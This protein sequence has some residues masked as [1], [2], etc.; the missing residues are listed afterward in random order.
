MSQYVLLIPPG[1]GELPVFGIGP[2]DTK[3]EA[4]RVAREDWD[5]TEWHVTKLIPPQ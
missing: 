5:D 4:E 3:E 1:K 2:F